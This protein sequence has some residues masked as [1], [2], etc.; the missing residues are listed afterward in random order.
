[1]GA[2]SHLL[3]DGATQCEQMTDTQTLVSFPDLKS[4]ILLNHWPK[5]PLWKQYKSLG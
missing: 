4:K 3:L 5:E 2:I 1:M